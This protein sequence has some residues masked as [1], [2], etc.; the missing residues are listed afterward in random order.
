MPV[1]YAILPEH[2]ALLYVCAGHVTG[3][4]LLAAERQ[5]RGDPQREMGASIVIDL[6]MVRE[7]DIELADWK[8]LIALNRQLQAS[9]YEPERTALIARGA[10]DFT[11]VGAFRLIA[12]AVVQLRIHVS[13][14]LGEA[15]GWHGISRAVEDVERAR[16]ELQLEARADARGAAAPRHDPA[17]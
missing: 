8:A 3:R 17:G 14:T 4:E 2:H 6:Q 11:L 15:L 10:H 13:E 1:R 5:A 12:D 7:L 16:R 9:G